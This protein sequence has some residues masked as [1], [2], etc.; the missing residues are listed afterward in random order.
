MGSAA[1]SM[2]TMYLINS[3]LSGYVIGKL[4]FE[5]WGMVHQMSHR[6]LTGDNMQEYSLFF[7]AIL[8]NMALRGTLP[9]AMGFETP[10]MPIEH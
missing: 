7:I 6:G 3:Y 5:P 1:I 4:P 2:I 8:C 10:R 9:K